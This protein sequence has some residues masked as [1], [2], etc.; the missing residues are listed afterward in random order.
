MGVIKP[1]FYPGLVFISPCVFPFS[2][3]PFPPPISWQPVPPGW[4]ELDSGEW[5]GWLGSDRGEVPAGPSQGQVLTVAD[6][7]GWR[8]DSSPLG[9]GLGDLSGYCA[10]WV[11]W[12]GEGGVA[13]RPR[14]PPPSCWCP[15]AA[16][17]PAA[18][19]LTGSTASTH[20]SAGPRTSCHMPSG[21][22]GPPGPPPGQGGTRLPRHPGIQRP[23]PCDHSSDQAGLL[24]AGGSSSCPRCVCATGDRETWLL[25]PGAGTWTR[26]GDLHQ[27]RREFHMVSLQDR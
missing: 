7:D 20:R 22:A 3:P 2:G 27:P 12:W 23:F 6:S 25:R 21:V 15:G 13:G 9:R 14:R 17:P 18:R 19:R 10:T 8:E 1:T 4:T 5:N 16:P 24:V 26:A 11:G